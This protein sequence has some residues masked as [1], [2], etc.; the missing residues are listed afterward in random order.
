VLGVFGGFCLQETNFTEKHIPHIQGYKCYNKNRANYIRAFGRVAIFIESSIPSKEIPLTI[1][2]E[3][4]AATFLSHHT[5][6]TLCNIYISNQTDLHLEDIDN[7]TKQLLSPS[8]ITV[9]FNCHSELW[10]SDKTDDRG[11]TMK[12]F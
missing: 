8:I 1:N 5:S 3:A 7:I 12:N 4:V 11:K 10:G 6:T 9:D 2:L